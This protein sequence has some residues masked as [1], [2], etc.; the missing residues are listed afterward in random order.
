MVDVTSDDTALILTFSPD[1]MAALE[2]AAESQGITSVD[3]LLYTL[4]T[5]YCQSDG[6]GVSFW[7]NADRYA[8]DPG[9]FAVSAEIYDDKLWVTLADESVIATPLYW[10]PFLDNAPPEQQSN[11]T[12]DGTE[13]FWPD[14]Q[15]G[16]AVQ[17]MIQ[18]PNDQI[19]AIIA[20]RGEN[21]RNILLPGF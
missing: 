11:F 6:I 3:A 14:L 13:I 16:V 4:L 18:G 5:D 10:Y 17:D 1:A 20:A 19:R 2:H 7:E 21:N 12:V 9:R 15:D 8:A